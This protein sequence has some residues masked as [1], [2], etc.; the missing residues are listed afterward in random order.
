MACGGGPV[1]DLPP[2]TRP[3]GRIYRPRAIKA[4]VLADEDDIM[5]GVM[6]TGTH[7][8]ERAASLARV[9]VASELGRG[10]EPVYSGCGWW[11]DGFECGRRCWVTDE[12]RGAAGVLF[13]RIEECPDGGR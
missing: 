4:H 2:I 5:C 1:N 13:G 3:D 9:L 8:E 7:D 6:V 12:V 10:Y 11:R